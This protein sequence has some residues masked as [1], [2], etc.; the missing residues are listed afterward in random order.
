VIIGSRVGVGGE[1]TLYQMP[2]DL[3]RYYGN[4]LP[5]GFQ[6]FFRI[7][8]SLMQDQEMM[9]SMSAGSEKQ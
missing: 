1:F 3:E 7:R 4:D 5:Y 8:P 2:D 6:F 9:H